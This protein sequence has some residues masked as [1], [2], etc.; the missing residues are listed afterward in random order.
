MNPQ[1]L[2]TELLH[3]WDHGELAPSISA[4]YPT[5]NWDQAYDVSAELIKLRRA[6][7]EKTVGRKIGFTNRNIWPQYGATSP[8]WHYVY[9]RTL[10]HAHE[11][12]ATLSLKHSCQPLIEPEIAFKLSG[13]VPVHCQ[14]PGEILHAIEWYAPSFEIVCCHYPG[15]KCTPAEF[16]ADFSLHWRLVVGTPVHATADTLTALAQQLGACAIALNKNGV[17]MDRG[18]G[19][20]AL[21][22]PALALAFLAD[23]LATQAAFDPLSAGEIITTGTLTNALPVAAGETWQSRYEGLDGVAGLTLNFTQ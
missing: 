2:A 12:N 9:D 22:H 14:D 19:S 11:G 21:D 23:T 3:A 13:P 17:V 20:N 16:A 8:I 10:V 6:R 4:R 1:T 7:G 5:F 18:K 15:W